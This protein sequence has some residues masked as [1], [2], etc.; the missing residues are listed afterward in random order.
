MHRVSAVAMQAT[1]LAGTVF[2]ILQM[3][4]YIRI[5]FHPLLK[6]IE[7]EAFQDWKK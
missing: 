1:R 7:N 2:R 6:T 3:D 4:A 5:I